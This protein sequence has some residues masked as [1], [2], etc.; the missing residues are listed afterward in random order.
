MTETEIVSLI[1]LVGWLVLMLGAYRAHQVGMQRTIVM[2]L[3]WSSIFLFV[4]MIFTA[5]GW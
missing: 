3:I 1:A 5:I 2:A 4:A